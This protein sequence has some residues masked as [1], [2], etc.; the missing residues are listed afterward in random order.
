MSSRRGDDGGDGGRTRALLNVVTEMLKD[1]QMS[2]SG[3]WRDDD[4]VDGVFKS[5]SSR[6]G[7]WC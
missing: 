2:S 6:G 5:A 3:E 1:P 7:C 4:D